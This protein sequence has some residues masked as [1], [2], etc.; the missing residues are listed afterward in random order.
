MTEK[1][2]ASRH[3]SFLRGYMYIGKSP[4]PIECLVRDISDTGARLKY[5]GQI[6][7]SDIINL[8]ISNKGEIFRAKVQWREADEIGISFVS[9]SAMS[10]VVSH[11]SDL[12]ERVAR[13]ETEIEAL[14]LINRPPKN[15]LDKADAA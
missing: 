9:N 5:S 2:R 3:K 4:F 10:G 8:H 11:D 1:R 6:L 15:A 13:L 14:K 12:T 7:A